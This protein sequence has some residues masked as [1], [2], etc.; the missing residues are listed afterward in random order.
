MT[1]FRALGLL[2]LILVLQSMVPAIWSELEA[3][4]IAFLHGARIS[5]GVATSIAASAGSTNLSVPLSAM[6]FTTPPFPLPQAAYTN[7]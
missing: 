6:P 3:T 1:I 7:L 5:A 4:I 2:V